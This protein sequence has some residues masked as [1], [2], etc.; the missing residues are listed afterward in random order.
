MHDFVYFH[1]THQQLTFMPVKN[2]K[3]FGLIECY[4]FDVQ[5]FIMIW[6]FQGSF[7]KSKASVVLKV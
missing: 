3:Q 6:A 5:I 7:N 1:V 2:V 4:S